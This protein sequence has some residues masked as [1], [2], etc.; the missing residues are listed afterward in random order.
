M[1]LK[2][3][4]RRNSLVIFE[5]LKRKYHTSARKSLWAHSAPFRVSVVKGRLVTIIFKVFFYCS[6]Y[7][8]V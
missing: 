3:D 6:R 8:L 2:V 5:M 4:S 1:E 7:S